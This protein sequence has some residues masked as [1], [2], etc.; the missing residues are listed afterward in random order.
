MYYTAYK[1]LAFF[2]GRNIFRELISVFLFY[3]FGHQNKYLSEQEILSFLMTET[4]IMKSLLQ[5]FVMKMIM[6][7]CGLVGSIKSPTE[8]GCEES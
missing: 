3:C 8:E 7:M 2:D 5:L 4:K 1:T 6:L